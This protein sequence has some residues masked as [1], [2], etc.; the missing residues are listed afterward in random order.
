MAGNLSLVA[1]A[2]SFTF[3]LIALASSGGGV[4]SIMAMVWI[5]RSRNTGLRAGPSEHS[6]RKNYFANLLPIFYLNENNVFYSS[7]F[8]DAY[9]T[10]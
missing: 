1:G 10:L 7:P 6:R 5:M 9:R 3:S 2:Y 8:E 4:T